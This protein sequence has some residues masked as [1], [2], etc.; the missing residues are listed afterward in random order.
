MSEALVIEIITSAMWTASQVAAPILVTAIVVGV[1]MG[2]LQSVTQIQEQTLAFVPK[3]AAVGV[4]I[5]LSGN[6][7]L[8]RM[9]DFTVELFGR[10]PALL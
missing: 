7:M 8:H 9:I 10:I 5:A 3:F 4:V 6:W 1:V 2:L